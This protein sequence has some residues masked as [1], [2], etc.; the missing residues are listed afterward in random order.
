MN[1]LWK[2]GANPLVSVVMT[3]YN[4]KDFIAQAIESII[5][6]KYENR[7]LII[8]D[9]SQNDETWEVIQ[10]YT[11]KYKDRI[12]AFHNRPNKGIVWNMKFLLSKRS[13][14]SQYTCFL[15][16]DDVYDRDNI[17]D[18]INIFLKNINTGLIYNNF[19]I[20]NE[21]W[22]IIQK[23]GL[24]KAKHYYKNEKINLD[25]VFQKDMTVTRSRSTIMV[26]NEMLKKYSI[27][28][29]SLSDY[30]LISDFIFFFTVSSNEYIY[31]LEK[32]LTLYRFHSNNTSNKRHNSLPNDMMECIDYFLDNWYIGLETW[33]S[34]K[35]RRYNIMALSDLKW[36]FNNFYYWI[37]LWGFKDFMKRVLQYM[38]GNIF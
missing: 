30:N 25:E 27:S 34:M 36:F 28:I 13:V 9:D 26:K 32:P 23:N 24:K 38:F 3:T 20:I 31:W 4:H 10:K 2:D 18:K 29:P 21:K 6:Q 1:N 14:N 12:K 19:S 11:P 15:E 33:K 37:K 17:Y 8:W 7:E 16:W 22:K 35:S 5:N